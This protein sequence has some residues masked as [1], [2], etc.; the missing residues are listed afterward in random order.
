MFELWCVCLL[1]RGYYSSHLRT[2]D[3]Q[4]SSNKSVSALVSRG[5][6]PIRLPRRC[7]TWWI[8]QYPRLM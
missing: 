6:K 7:S 5:P 1:L 8:S 2:L 3:V 4:Q